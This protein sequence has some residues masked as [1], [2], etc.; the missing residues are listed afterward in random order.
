MK[1]VFLLAEGLCDDPVPELDGRTPLEIA[2]TP[3]LDALA[4]KGRVGSTLFVPRALAPS[5]DVAC[6]AALG[7][8]PQEFYTGIA[9]LEAAA[10]G[11]PQKDREV[12]FRLDLV[13]VFDDVL[14]DASAGSIV[15]KESRLLIEELGRRLA[16]KR[17][18]LYPGEGYKN[19]LMIDDAELADALDDLECTPP[20]RLVGQSF[21]K[22]L[23]KGKGGKILT[24]FMDASK[25]ILDNNEINR[26]RIDLGENPANMVWPWGQ[27]KRPPLPGFRERYGVD[28]AV[29]SEADFVRGLGRILGLKDGGIRAPKSLAGSFGDH[30]FVFVYV[31]FPGGEAEPALKDR[32]RHIEEFDSAVVGPAVKA[33][34][35]AGAF[36]VCVTTTC[37]ES[38]ARKAKIHERV[39]FV[40]QGSGIEAGEGAA[41]SEKIASQS[42][43]VVEEGHKLMG[44]FLGK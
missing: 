13:T 42:R 19:I 8:D 29:F 35:S 1:H 11:L 22:G 23:P 36:R 20:G 25:E 17:M 9:P 39:P 18:R 14:V 27:G 30:P 2:K 4:K 7:F 33:A 38:S 21:A 6:M 34:E 16:D 28:G 10:F 32:V 3:N 26:V 40:F 43:F 12:A 5:E 24:D 41:F 15:P 31:P 44:Q 37:A